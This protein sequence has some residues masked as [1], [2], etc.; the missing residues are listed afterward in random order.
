MRGNEWYQWYETQSELFCE[1]FA[2]GAMVVQW[3]STCTVD[4]TYTLL[5]KRLMELWWY[6][7]M[8]RWRLVNECHCS[9]YA[10][11]YNTIRYPVLH[12]KQVHH[13]YTITTTP[14][15]ASLR[16]SWWRRYG[17]HGGR[18]GHY[19]RYH[20]HPHSNIITDD[21]TRALHRYMELIRDTYG[22]WYHCVW[23]WLHQSDGSV[24]VT[25]KCRSRKQLCGLKNCCGYW[26]YRHY[27]HALCAIN[28]YERGRET[29][30]NSSRSDIIMIVLMMHSVSVLRMRCENMCRSA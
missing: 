2:T 29:T 18:L 15:Q 5:Y 23:V 28:A 26:Q 3:N 10:V 14:T 8:W 24:A 11:L 1:A 25:D 17:L 16:P 19:H 21:V 20:H 12:H 22:R 6:D 30:S 7:W 13:A 4:N 27:E 9:A